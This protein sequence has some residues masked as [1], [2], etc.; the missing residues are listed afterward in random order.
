ME[1]V[2]RRPHTHP[3]VTSTPPGIDWNLASHAR[4][5]HSFRYL[6]T[7]HRVHSWANQYNLS[8]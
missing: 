6:K 8:S 7:S 3:E 2:I 1:G 4:V 5:N